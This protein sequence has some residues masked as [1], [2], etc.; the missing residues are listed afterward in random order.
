[1]SGICLLTCSCMTLLTPCTH[2]ICLSVLNVNKFGVLN[3]R[4][5]ESYVLSLGKQ[6]LVVFGCVA[7]VYHLLLSSS[8]QWRCSNICFIFARTNPVLLL[9]TP[10]CK[11]LPTVWQPQLWQTSCLPHTWHQIG[12]I[13][14]I[15]PKV[16][17]RTKHKPNNVE[18]TNSTTNYNNK[19]FQSQ[20][21][22]SRLKLKLIR[23]QNQAMVLACG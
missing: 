10:C 3:L 2:W 22:S 12:V 6:N 17:E 11:F 4:S 18:V 9:T 23:S 16:L 21:S 19:A 14:C 7:F 20:T 8:M 15:M 5:A 1:M 13:K